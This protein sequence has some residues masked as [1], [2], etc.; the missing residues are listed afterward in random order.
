MALDGSGGADGGPSIDDLL[1]LMRGA[2][3]PITPAPDPLDQVSNWIAAQRWMPPGG[4]LFGSGYARYMAAHASPL[5]SGTGWRGPNGL[6]P[7][8]ASPGASAA[9]SPTRALDDAE[10]FEP[11]IAPAAW[12]GGALPID[13]GVFRPTG[14]QP[15]VLPVAAPQRAASAA[16]AGG[17]DPL[18]ALG[19]AIGGQLR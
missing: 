3:A 19:G 14:S 1:Q 18:A 9:P 10:G 6:D 16:Q 4:G 7:T 15:Q 2:R 8:T 12:S 11:Q 5:P 17:P 13:D